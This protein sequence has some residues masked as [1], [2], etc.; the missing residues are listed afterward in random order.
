M[1]VLNLKGKIIDIDD[2]PSKY[3]MRTEA[4]CKSKLQFECGQLLRKR[5]AF[6][7]ILEEVYIPD[8]FYLDFFIPVRKLAFEIHGRQHD[9]YVSYFHG[10]KKEFEQSRIRDFNKATWC[11]MNGINLY[12]VRSVKEMKEILE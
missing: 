2:N 3:P 1:K 6:D 5:F 9:E 8:G 7:A 12:I 4:G 10:S 11:E